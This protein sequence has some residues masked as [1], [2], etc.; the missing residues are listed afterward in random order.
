[1]KTDAVLCFDVSLKN[2]SLKHLKSLNRE[3]KYK[4][5]KYIQKSEFDLGTQIHRNEL[6]INLP[7][8]R[9]YWEEHIQKIYDFYYYFQVLEKSDLYVIECFEAFDFVDANPSSER[10][11]FIVKRKV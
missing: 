10:V 9:T 7:D 3:G 8:G 5:I 1:M 6:F 4:G 2:N 11:Q